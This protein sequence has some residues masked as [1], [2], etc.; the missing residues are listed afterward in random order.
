MGGSVR[1]PAALS[2]CIGFKPSLGRIPMDILPTVFDTISHFGPLGR[3]IDDIRMFMNVVSGPDNADILSQPHPQ[4]LIDRAR[5]ASHFN[6]A[7]SPDLGF[8]EVDPDVAKNFD[9]CLKILSD[10]GATITEVD[11]NW[12]S[13]IVD[14]W[15][16]YWCVYLAAAAED[17]LADH[18]QAMDPEFLELVDR[19]L[20]MS[21]VSFRR[22]DEVRTKQWHH[23]ARAISGYDALLCPTMALPAPAIDASESDFT[24]MGP[25]GRLKGLDMTCMFNS[26]GQCPALSVPSGLSGDGLP[27]AVQIIGQRF[28]DST[29]L[30]IGEIIQNS[31]DWQTTTSPLLSQYN[32]TQTI[33]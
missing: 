12:S 32:F 33:K 26:I 15:Y 5:P 14:A 31:L 11:L 1:I 6:L 21:A 22:L 13:E 7:V 25:N 16:D 8:Y 28:D 27:T 3:H 9:H 24:T 4:P 19:G 23:F 29:V 30:E 18:R 10:A 17:L 20:S 2:G